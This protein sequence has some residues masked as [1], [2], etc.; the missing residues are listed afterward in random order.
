MAKKKKTQLKPVARP[1]ATASV[2]K[3]I[4]PVDV[5]PED[6]AAEGGPE[7][8]SIAIGVASEG[9]PLKGPGTTAAPE[10]E[11]E[12]VRALKAEEKELQSL[13]DKLQDKTEKEINRTL[14]ARPNTPVLSFYVDAITYTLCLLGFG[15]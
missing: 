14:K 7:G 5:V 11:S 3:K 12:E 4:V 9:Q 2:P 15:V 13:I 8:S 6:E 1:I 10:P